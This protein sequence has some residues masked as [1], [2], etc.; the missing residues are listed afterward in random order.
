[1]NL[2]YPR[3][4]E[5]NINLPAVK[6][7]RL[8]SL[9]F[10]IVLLGCVII[11]AIFAQHIAPYDPVKMLPMDRL[12]SPS[13]NHLFGTDLMGRD[14]FS[15]VI[16]GARI[17]LMVAVV[18]VLVSAIPGMIC[19]MVG[20]MYRGWLTLIMDYCMDAWMAIP[21]LLVVIALTAAFDREPSTLAIAL[22][23]AGVPSFYRL[24]RGEALKQNTM[25]Y[26]EAAR[27][28]GAKERYILLRH[29]LPNTLPTLIIFSTLRMG[30]LLITISAFSFIGLGAQPP[31]PEWGA[32]LAESRDYFHQAWWL[33]VFPGLAIM[34]TVFGLNLLGDGLRDFLSK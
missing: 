6:F 21:G 8:S 13:L 16:F 11:P 18:A 7:P 23:I 17:S 12:Q 29:V 20:G 33:M 15:R 31:D 9:I 34:I 28:V 22:G 10:G 4:V 1:M 24:T 25:L 2:T 32:L 19:G 27:A 14:L 3:S 30:G 5:I 26:I